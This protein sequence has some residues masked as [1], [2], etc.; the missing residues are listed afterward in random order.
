[1]KKY[2]EIYND[3]LDYKLQNNETMKGWSLCLSKK[4]DET[5]LKTICNNQLYD[6]RDWLRK[7]KC[8]CTGLK[9]K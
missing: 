9:E 5:H 2:N 3:Y 7:C 6:L 8:K 4:A 1:M